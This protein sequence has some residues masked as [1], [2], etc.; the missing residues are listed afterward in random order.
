VII[1]EGLSLQGTSRHHKE[2]RHHKKNSK[3]EVS[4]SE[5]TEGEGEKVKYLKP[6]NQD[7]T[8]T[9]STAEE[10][11]SKVHSS[12]TET[13]KTKRKTN[14]YNNII[15]N[16]KMTRTKNEVNSNTDRPKRSPENAKRM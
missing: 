5:T 10:I 13:T 2:Q 16:K 1:V 15:G 11:A 9:T 3:Q 4:L 6:L 12:K 14:N 8:S 7:E